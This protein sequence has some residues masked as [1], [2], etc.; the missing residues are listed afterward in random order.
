MSSQRIDAVGAVLKGRKDHDQHASLHRLDDR[1]DAGEA[2]ADRC[3]P[4]D[5]LGHDGLTTTGQP[6]CSDEQAGIGL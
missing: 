4:A 6:R 3:R 5:A 1:L 2:R